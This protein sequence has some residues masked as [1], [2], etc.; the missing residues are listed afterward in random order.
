MQKKVELSF[1]ISLWLFSIIL[2]LLSFKTKQ[3]SLTENSINAYNDSM[4]G[5]TSKVHTCS[6]TTESVLEFTAVLD[7]G[8]KYPIAGVRLEPKDGFWNLVSYDFV[9]ISLSPNTSDFNFTMTTFVEGLST[10]N[11]P[12]NHRYHQMDYSADG[13]SHISFAIDDLQTPA[14]WYPLNSVK[15]EEIGKP[16]YEKVTALIFSNHP[17]SKVSD[18]VSF[19]INS[20]TLSRNRLKPL[21]LLLVSLFITGLYTLFSRFQ[22]GRYRTILIKE[23]IEKTQSK[24]E[25]LLITIGTLFSEPK[26]TIEKVSHASGVSLYHIRNILKEEFDSNFLEYLKRV[27]VEKMKQLLTETDKDI[28]EISFS[29]GFSHASTATRSFKE[30]TGSSPS[31]F[32]A[33]QGSL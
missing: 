7:S 30:L 20:V 12:N 14:W 23:G 6:L 21:F 18:T 11:D 26:L 28:K 10:E 9:T 13:S 8:A 17:N 1:I 19:A 5:G 25:R 16:A 33:E 22:K 15:R 2:V 4:A 32:R 24:K 29:V 3:I 27:R 31:V